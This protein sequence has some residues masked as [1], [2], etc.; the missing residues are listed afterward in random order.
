MPAIDNDEYRR[1]LKTIH[2]KYGEHNAILFGDALQALAL[3]F[4]LEDNTFFESQNII[5]LAKIFTDIIGPNKLL[6]GQMLD[7]NI[8][9]KT[10]LNSK[11]DY[12]LIFKIHKNKTAVFFAFCAS[13]GGILSGKIDLSKKAYEFGMNFG[14]AFQ[15]FDD[16]NDFEKKNDEINILNII[17]IDDAKK[18]LESNINFLENFI[19]E[20]INIESQSIFH[21]LISILK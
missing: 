12:D 16:I 2:A 9:K 4:F 15:I 5:N 19:K 13:M 6:L 10:F 17:K 1:G 7:I 3:N 21:E 14:L 18:L 20:Q 8:T 11:I